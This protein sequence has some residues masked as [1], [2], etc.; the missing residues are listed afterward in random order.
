MTKRGEKT[1]AAG[2]G[3][4]RGGAEGDVEAAVRRAVDDLMPGLLEGYRAKIDEEISDLRKSINQ[5]GGDLTQKI[6]KLL[7]RV[8]GLEK[9]KENSGPT[10]LD[11][12]GFT[13]RGLYA[14]TEELQRHMKGEINVRMSW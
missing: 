9:N 3:R 10:T 12:T 11:G 13:K 6:D 2:G 1:A 5:S 7:E 14:T 8:D 4:R